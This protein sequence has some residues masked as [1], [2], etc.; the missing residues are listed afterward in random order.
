MGCFFFHI[1]FNM[2]LATILPVDTKTYVS[3]LQSL[4]ITQS[5]VVDNW[6]KESESVIGLTS[7]G[8]GRGQDL[9]HFLSEEDIGLSFLYF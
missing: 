4:L 2:G 8:S 6:E 7:E 3:L 1:D 9:K 5:S